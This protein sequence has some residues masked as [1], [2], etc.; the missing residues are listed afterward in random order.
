M[1]WMRLLSKWFGP[2]S[3]QVPPAEWERVLAVIRSG[4]SR[5]VH[6]IGPRDFGTSYTAHDVRSLQVVN[7][8][9][10]PSDLIIDPAIE[11]EITKRSGIRRRGYFDGMQIE[12]DLL[13]IPRSRYSY[14][15]KFIP[16]AEVVK[17]EVFR[18][19]LAFHYA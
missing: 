14:G 8:K 3:F 9:G 12:G 4:P 2:E 19:R 11:V 10:L 1:A 17:V 6:V 15:M 7:G 13:L 5:E 18:G 16:L